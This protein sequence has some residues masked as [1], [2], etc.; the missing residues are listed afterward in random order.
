MHG[1][2]RS[3]GELQLAAER[4]TPRVFFSSRPPE[5]GWDTATLA[6]VDSDARRRSS[7]SRAA[8]RRE[9]AQPASFSEAQ[10]H[11]CHSEAGA[12][13]P[14][15]CSTRHASH[16]LRGR[17]LGRPTHGLSSVLESRCSRS[18]GLE[19]AITIE[20]LRDPRRSPPPGFIAGIRPHDLHRPDRSLETRS[21]W[22]SIPTGTSRG[23]AIP[24]AN[25]ARTV[26]T[27]IFRAHW[28]SESLF[29]RLRHVKYMRMFGKSKG[30]G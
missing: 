2:V 9:R 4:F 12:G 23:A 16:P 10:G 15:G 11:R 25:F 3:L 29:Q 20:E 8:N 26:L 17:C 13:T 6:K 7:S 24:Y 19:G 5:P 27:M 14:H 1:R 28:C 18:T 21:P 22:R 30:G